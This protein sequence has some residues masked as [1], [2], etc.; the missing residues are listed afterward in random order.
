MLLCLLILGSIATFYLFLHHHYSYWKRRG[1]SQL[2]PS[3]AFGDFGPVIRGRANFVH[4]LQGIYERTKR[5]YSLLGLYVLFR[6]ALLVNDFVVARDILSRDFQHFGDRGIYVD[7]KRDP[8]SGHLFALDGER[9]RHVRH[10]VA[11]A[12]TPLKLKDVFQTQ[13]IGGVVLQDH[14]KHFAESGQSVDVADLFL[15]YSVDMIA[16]VAFGVEIDSVNCPE[17]QFYRVAHSSV[18]SNVKNLLR[19]TGGFLIPKV[20]KYTGTR[21]VDQHVQDFFMHVVQ[22]TV[23]YREKTGFTRRDVLQSLLKIMN[24]ES[25]NVSIDF[26]ITDLTVTAFTFLLAGMETSS[27]TA[28]FCLYEIVNNQE[29]Q[30]RLQKEIDE[31]L[32]E[33]DGLITYDSVVA[34]KYLDHCVNEAMRKFPALAYLHRICTE[35]YL[36]PSTRT[37]IK[38]GTLVLI[39]IYALQRDQEFF[40]HPDLFLPDRFNDP[41]AIRQAPFFPFGEGP[42]SCIGQ[43]MGKMNVKIALVHLLSRYNF[44]LANP[45][46][47]GREAPIDPLHFTISP[48]GSFNMNVTHRKCSSPSSHSKSLTNHSVSLAH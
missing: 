11:P 27:S 15:R 19:W 1:I 47:Q 2:K 39:P 48:Q 34:M 45:V 25:Q 44:T 33:H 16:S 14:L 22:Q 21:L 24:A 13:L 31:S 29:I 30:R 40:P 23:E 6:P 42:R 12:F 18:E 41:E 28:T 37:I 9:W 20:L 7:E 10:K 43:R 4:H 17:E 3:F 32:Q 26:T 8:F 46:D 38:K 5:D 35:D 36:V